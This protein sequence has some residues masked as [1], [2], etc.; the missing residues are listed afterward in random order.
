MSFVIQLIYRGLDQASRTGISLTN[1]FSLVFGNNP[2][3]QSAME[4][5][6]IHHRFSYT[7]Y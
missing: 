2:I 7:R 4:T 6:N 1:I 5:T 3:F